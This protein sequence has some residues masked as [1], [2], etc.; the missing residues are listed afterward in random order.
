[1]RNS[2][3]ASVVEAH[4][5]ELIRD[6]LKYQVALERKGSDAVNNSEVNMVRRRTGHRKRHT[7][8]PK[9]LLYEG[10]SL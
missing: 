9:G 4:L 2:G 5:P 3:H 10:T 7:G 1:M 8:Y 6:T